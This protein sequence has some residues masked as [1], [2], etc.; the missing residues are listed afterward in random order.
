MVEGPSLSE[1]MPVEAELTAF[2]KP[3]LS[4][5]MTVSMDLAEAN[6]LWLA[7]LASLLGAEMGGKGEV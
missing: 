1:A 7:A 3:P 4:V 5:V 6:T 2:S